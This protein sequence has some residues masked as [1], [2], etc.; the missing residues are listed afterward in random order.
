MRSIKKITKVRFPLISQY[1]FLVLS[2][3]PDRLFIT[4][5][6]AITLKQIPNLKNP[7]KFNEKLQWIK[8][9]W[10]D[11]V[12]VM[13]ADKVGV[14]EFVR[15]RGCGEI[16]NELYGIYDKAEDI[17]FS[18][19]P[20]SFVLKATHG[21][22]WNIVCQDKSKI[23][24]EETVK[25]IKLWLN[26]SYYNH[27]REWVYRDIKP[28]IVCEKYLSDGE[29]EYLRDF[30]FYCFHGRPLY[31]QVIGDRHKGKVV[32]FYDRDWSLMPFTGSHLP[33][34]SSP[35]FSCPLSKPEKYEYMLDIAEKL[36]RDFAFVRVDL[37]SLQDKVY[38]GELTFFPFGGL[39]EFEP[40]EWNYKLGDLID[41]NVF[42][43]F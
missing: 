24:V 17:D 9:N 10:H 12:A 23:D 8:L 32:D 1:V 20:D 13:C 6:Y 19:M 26:S 42:H 15:L 3:I 35:H 27:A 37:Y 2:V 21:S 28:R 33:G 16:L 39:G 5:R 31:C 7:M 18:V 30:K 4:M 25:K 34:K 14:R 36:S 40:Y 38:F 41:L 22:G 11:P 43:K 29:N